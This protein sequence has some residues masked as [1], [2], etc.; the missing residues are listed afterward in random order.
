MWSVTSLTVANLFENWLMGAHF[1]YM[2][3]GSREIRTPIKTVR[4]YL[5][6]NPIKKNIITQMASLGMERESC[7]LMRLSGC[8]HSGPGKLFQRNLISHVWNAAYERSKLWND[9][10]VCPL[11][12]DA[13]VSNGSANLF[14]LCLKYDIIGWREN[15]ILF[16]LFVVFLFVCLFRINL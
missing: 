4:H 15:P 1:E 2:D 10:A 5:K 6:T 8:F 3:T 9:R 14:H 16:C 11:T 13:Q 12:W 7:P